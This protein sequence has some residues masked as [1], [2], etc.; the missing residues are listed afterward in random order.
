MT[1][2]DPAA[3]T[4]LA[5]VLLKVE[6]PEGAADTLRESANACKPCASDD[7]WNHVADDVAR[8]FDAKSAK[9]L[10][11]GDAVGAQKSA[12]VAAALRPNLPETHLAL[13]KIAR[14]QGNAQG[15][16]NEYRKAVERLPDAK[17]GA[18]ATARLELATLLLSNGGGAEAVKLAEQVIAAHEDDPAALDT[19]GRACDATR[20]TDCARK[21]YGKLVKLPTGNE[22][23]GQTLTHARLRVKEL[24]SRRH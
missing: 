7:G 11:S 10:A 19:L 5:D 21:A 12:D 6:K 24:K 8:T 20:D 17:A 16:T 1:P 14:A 4:Q 9:Q 13:G 2:R 3:W 18:G 23:S 22:V 15:A